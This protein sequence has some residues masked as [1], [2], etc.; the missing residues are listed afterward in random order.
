MNSKENSPYTDNPNRLSDVIAAIQVMGTYK[1]F[2][3]EFSEWAHRISG[4]REKGNHWKQIFEQ[5]PEFFRLNRPRT[6]ASLAWR[7]TYRKHYDVDADATLS[8][9]ACLNLTKEQK[10]RI[11]RSPLSNDDI[12]TLINTAINLHARELDRK[13]DSRWWITGIIGLAGVILGALIKAI[14]G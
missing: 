4:D 1:F 9:E 14:A 10:K 6:H 12:S 7:R 11:S 8:K 5:H 13:K 3:L 2:K